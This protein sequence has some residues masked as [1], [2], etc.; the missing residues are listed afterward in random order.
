MWPCVVLQ[1]EKDVMDISLGL[2]G[3]DK[4]MEKWS[5]PVHVAH[6]LGT[7]VS[8]KWEPEGRRDGKRAL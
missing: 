2:L 6:V 8:E 5:Q 3:M 4:H 1:F 7:L